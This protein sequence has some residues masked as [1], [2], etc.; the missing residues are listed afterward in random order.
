[1]MFL[2]KDSRRDGYILSVPQMRHRTVNKR[3]FR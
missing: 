1:M 3:K 2:L